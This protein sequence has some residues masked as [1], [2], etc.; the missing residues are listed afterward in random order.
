MCERTGTMQTLTLRETARRYR[1][2]PGYLSE[3]VR[4]GKPVK[5]NPLHENAV[6]EDGRVKEFRFPD[7]HRFP[8][9]EL[10]HPNPSS[11]LVSPPEPRIPS[12]EVK[13]QLQRA[14]TERSHERTFKCAVLAR[15]VSISREM[16]VVYPVTQGV[17]MYTRGLMR[18]QGCLLF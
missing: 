4:E 14:N 2:S 5:G 1:C 6:I 10:I 8:N 9:G 16:S 13:G 7:S 11:S 17:F 18:M 12:L 15:K 3:R